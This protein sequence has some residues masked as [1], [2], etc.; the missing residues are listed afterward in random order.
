MA[1]K[2][3]TEKVRGRRW[4]VGVREGTSDVEGCD[5]RIGEKM[6]MELNNWMRERREIFGIFF[7]I[8]I[9]GK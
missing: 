2:S 4:N 9:I 3:A 1:P 7:S 6:G 5:W 8:I